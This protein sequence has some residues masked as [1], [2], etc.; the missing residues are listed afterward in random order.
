MHIIGLLFLFVPA[1]CIGGYQ[2]ALESKG[3]NDPTL[4]LSLYKTTILIDIAF[5]LCLLCFIS[6]FDTYVLLSMF[7]ILAFYF[8]FFFRLSLTIPK[9][10][11]R[12][13]RK[14]PQ[15]TNYTLCAF[16]VIIW[17]FVS[18]A[19]N[20]AI[21]FLLFSFENTPEV[22]YCCSIFLI[23]AILYVILVA[24]ALIRLDRLKYPSIRSLN[25]L[26]HNNSPI[27]M[28][29]SFKIDSNP[30]MNG[31][32]FDETI[33]ENLDLEQNPI[34]SLANPDEILPSGGSLKIQTKDSEWK[35]VVKEVLKNCRAVVL[36][37]GLSDGLHWEISKLKEYI[38]PEQLYVLIPSKIYRELAWCFEN[39]NEKGLFSIMRN[40][41]RFSSLI[42]YFTRKDI[43]KILNAVWI[44]FSSKL[45]QFD[46]KTPENFPG[47]ECLM[48]FD[49][50][51]NALKQDNLHNIKAMMDYIVS[52]TKSF[53][54]PN[55]D[56]S[57][58]GT[59]IA[60]YEVNGFL[61]RENIAPFKKLVNNSIT[62]GRIIAAV[63][64]L[65]F[66]ISMFLL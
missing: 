31:K 7:V 37:E 54:N 27:V 65:V 61:K 59:K 55:F 23:F 10:S 32:V 4:S 24:K 60:S 35:E 11:I 57:E 53:N 43:N 15:E 29:R 19:F 46:I 14:F 9:I 42:S 6:E 48:S 28:L 36:V 2:T 18:L 16:K 12:R 58:L 20:M 63:C 40:I 56:Y 22:L 26:A 41:S 13:N 44:D 17:W 1:L 21:L 50:N 25:A 38:K 33:C 66:L 47:N 8:L 39:D 62:I 5:K 51:W 49:D 3:L 34:I 30:T 45:N 52:R 64:F